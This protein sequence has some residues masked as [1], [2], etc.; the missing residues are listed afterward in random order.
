MA[1]CLFS[2][3]LSLRPVGTKPNWRKAEKRK[4]ERLLRTQTEFKSNIIRL[5]LREEAYVP[6]TKK[7]LQ[8]K[9]LDKLRPDSIR[10]N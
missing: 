8:L 5:D 4:E 1:P 9:E 7:M 10:L 3:D 2:G 6:I